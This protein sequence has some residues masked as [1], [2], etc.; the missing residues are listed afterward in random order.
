MKIQIVKLQTMSWKSFFERILLLI[1]FCGLGYRLPA[2]VDS[3]LG[4]LEKDYPQEKIY[5]HYDRPYYNTGETIWFKSYVFAGNLPSLISKTLYAE[6]I[7]EKGEV[8]QRKTIPVLGAG[9]AGDFILPDS[10]RSS[11][12]YVRAYTPWM[13]NF[14]SSFYYLKP[15]RIIGTQAKTEKIKEPLFSLQFFPEGGD[16][17]EGLESRVAFKATDDQGF[18]IAIKGEIVDSRQQKITSFSDM[19][20]GMGYFIFQPAAGEKYRAVWKDRKGVIQETALPVPKENGVVLNV[21]NNGNNITYSLIRSE[22]IPA[23]ERI[24]QVVAHQQQ[25]TIYLARINMTSKNKVTAPIPSEG[26]PDGIVHITLFTD[27]GR[28]LAERIVFVNHN[29]YY[30]ITDIHTKEKNFSKKGKNSIQVDVGDTLVSNLSVS[31]TDA[32]NTT[33]SR[34]EE[35]IFS[36]ILL[37]SDIKGYIFNP[38]YYFSGTADSVS[39]HLDLVMMTHGWRRFKWDDITAGRWPVIK[40]Y[41]QPYV[42]VKGQVLGLLQS[43]LTGKELTIVLQTKKSNTQVLSVPVTPKGEFS[44]DNLIFYDTAKLYYQFNNDKGRKLTSTA[45]FNFR[46]SF[47]ILPDK[48]VS[49]L[50]PVLKPVI[51]DSAAQKKNERLAKLR[52]DEFF[53]GQK[54][55]LLEGVEVTSR[56]KSTAQKMDEQYTSGFFSG[57]DGY[58]FITADDPLASSSLS[59]LDY[60]QGKVAGLQITSTGAQGGSLSWRGGTPSLFLNEMNSDVS[61]IQSTQMSDVA[62]IKVFRPPFFGAMGGG[63]GG[64]IAVYTKKG[65]EAN[66]SVKGLDFISVAGYSATREFYS[67][68]YSSPLADKDKNDY[69]TTLYWNP[70][71]VFDKQSRRIII[72]FFNNDNCKKIR[73][74]IEGINEVG[75]LTREEKYF[76]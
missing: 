33:A 62:M 40:A 39:E 49:G 71:L 24:F 47:L 44:I 60:L 42:T 12:V 55:K 61:L 58:T 18:P 7:D 29:N 43:D 38:A 68:D 66:S 51:P 9:A 1:L 11:L 31:V 75:K 35:N 5:I 27:N 8:L 46:N 21:I 30:F 14:D 4:I 59:V 53:E 72:P 26:L 10:M 3:L 64:A 41:P 36:H 50:L 57:G 22:T 28:A 23:D 13:L 48:P 37:S 19:H 45:S 34:E 65:A 20:D 25:A 16:L 70:Y 32:G 56:Q 63:A 2:Q 17:V 6:L 15:I 69:R 52:R 76:E 67:P 74:V 73:V 54:V